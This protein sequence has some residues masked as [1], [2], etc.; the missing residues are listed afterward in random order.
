MKS[1][2][3]RWKCKLAADQTCANAVALFEE[4]EKGDREVNRL[5]GDAA[6]TDQ[7]GSIQAA[8]ENGLDAIVDKL[9]TNI[10]DQIN[11]TVAAT[12]ATQR[13]SAIVPEQANAIKTA[14][15]ELQKEVKNLKDQVNYLKKRVNE[16]SGNGGG[17]DGNNSQRGANKENMESNSDR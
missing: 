12:L 15:D 6:S 14:N 16:L 1:V 17:G 10:Q 13:K 8:L 7:F 4:E 5:M 2:I 9:N 3:R 11:A